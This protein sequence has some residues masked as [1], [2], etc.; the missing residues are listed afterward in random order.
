MLYEESKE[1]AAQYL[2]LIVP[3]LVALNLPTNPVNY[4]LWYQYTTGSNSELNQEI[5][6]LLKDAKVFSKE[7]A[8]DLYYRHILAEDTKAISEANLSLKKIFLD[9][10]ES[11]KAISDDSEDFVEL[12]AH[13]SDTITDDTD[14]ATF[15]F[16]IQKTIDAASKIQ[17]TN[18]HYQN[19]FIQKAKE[20][21]KLKHDFEV[22]R[23]ESITDALTQINN[24]KSFNEIIQ[25]LSIDAI[26]QK[27]S[28]CLALID[29]DFFKTFNDEHGHLIGDQVLR[30]VAQSIVKNIKG[31]DF[32]ARFG[33]EKFAVLLPDTE[34]KG[35]FFTADNIRKNISKSKML[36]KKS[37]VEIGNIQVSIGVA[38]YINGESTTDLIDR[39]DK[40]LYEAKHAGRNTVKSKPE[41]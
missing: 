26:Q 4:A 16:E 24:R 31:K 39:A 19:K 10:I 29:I 5:D 30:F 28:L 22:V 12:L 37:K 25:S 11:V 2:R 8:R 6:E 40:A 35:A 34:L 7:I 21:E 41:L 33:G 17:N 1:K 9:L 27:T 15:K 14:L 20:L 13:Q 18:K 23:K 3:K 38:E 36:N 32:A